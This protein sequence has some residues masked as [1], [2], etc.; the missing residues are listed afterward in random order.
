MQTYHL[1]PR[2]AFTHTQGTVWG[3]GRLQ[4]PSSR[5]SRGKKMFKTPSELPA[6]SIMVVRSSDVQPWAWL[7]WCLAPGH[8]GTHEPWWDGTLRDGQWWPGLS[9][10]LDITWSSRTMEPSKPSHEFCPFG[11]CQQWLW[12]CLSHTNPSGAEN[13]FLASKGCHTPKDTSK[14]LS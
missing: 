8:S 6:C 11:R 2:A 14:R 9:A 4:A 3:G 13:T 12:R 1:G 5:Q 10:T 7:Q